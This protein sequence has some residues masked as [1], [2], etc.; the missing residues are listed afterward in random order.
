MSSEPPPLPSM[1]GGDVNKLHPLYFAISHGIM[2]NNNGDYHQCRKSYGMD[3]KLFVAA[4]YHNHKERRNGMRPVVT[5]VA[6]E[7][8]VGKT[9]VVKIERELM[10]NA[11]ILVPEEIYLARI[12]PIGPGSR[13]MSNE[14]I[15]ILYLLYRQ[16]PMWSLKSYVY[17]LFCCMGAIVLESTVSR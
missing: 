11:R 6:M 13:S 14:E 3:V 4:K 17:W 8:S 10:E 9:S 5:K 15:F 7:C 12:N 2:V 1:A 16:D